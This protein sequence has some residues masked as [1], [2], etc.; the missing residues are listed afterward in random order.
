M[1]TKKNMVNVMNRKPEKVRVWRPKPDL[2]MP[3]PNPNVQ[4]KARTEARIEAYRLVFGGKRSSRGK[5]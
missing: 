4:H 3:H 2:K 1:M 5:R